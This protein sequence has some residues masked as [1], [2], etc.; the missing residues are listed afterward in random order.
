MP[1]EAETAING[2]N[3][4]SGLR[5]QLSAGQ[6]AMVAVGGSIGTGLLLGSAAA[7][8]IAGPAVILSFVLAGFISWTVTMALGELSSVHPAAGSFGLYADLYLGPWA[9]FI[10]RAGYW[11]AISVSVGANLV[12]SATYMRYWFPT[13]PALVW[14]AVF[15]AALIAVNL[16]S[17]SDY[18]RFEY[19]FAM[20]KLVTMVT[21]IVIGAAVLADGRV[22]A[23]FTTQGG[24]FPKGPVAPLLAMTFALYTFGGIEM[25][26]I[27]TGEARTAAEIP[28]A[29][30]STFITLA[31]VYLG[32]IVVLVGVMPWNH[33]GV[34]ESPFVTVFRTVG[35]PA[36]SSLMS[37]VILTAAL[38]GANANWYVASRMLFSLARAGWAPAPL[39]RLNAAGSP[40]LALLASSYGIVVAVVLEKWAAKNAFVYILSG[41]LFGL[42]LSW[43]VSLAAHISFRRQIDAAQI[44]TLP[45]RSPLGAW[46]SMLGL[47]LVTAAILKT[48]WD[49]RVSLLSGVSTLL[50][51]TVVYVFLRSTN[52]PMRKI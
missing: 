5:H 52:T 33:V 21:F 8:E 24:F 12:A 13:V 41:A 32:A 45:M 10:S 9:G 26:A 48:W 46:G 37:F 11:I 1:Q 25:V 43:L 14:I 22:P 17:V 30:K 19:W 51:L 34:T 29:V 15:S 42:M 50:I 31:L 40:N 35:I 6:M 39:G 18:G 47:A 7:M 3:Q 27:T 49:S 44:A 36:A 2:I 28:R 23:Q 4:E 16:R 38:S 20:V